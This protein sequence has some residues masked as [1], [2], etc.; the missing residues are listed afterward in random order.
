LLPEFFVRL[1]KATG[2]IGIGLPDITALSQDPLDVPTAG[3]MDQDPPTLET[4]IDQTE[5][6]GI[7]TAPTLSDESGDD[8]GWTEF[9]CLIRPTDDATDNLIYRTI[10][11]GT[12]EITQDTTRYVGVEYNSGAPQVVARTS[13]TFNAGTDEFLMAIVYNDG[14][15]LHIRSLLPRSGNFQYWANRRLYE[16]ERLQHQ[17]GLALGESAGANRYVTMSAGA[18]YSSLEK[19]SIS[20]FDTSGADRFDLYYRDA[21]SGFTKVAS[22]QSWPN[23]QYDDDSGTL[24][25]LTAAYYG[26]LWFYIETDGHVVCLY[27]RGN[28]QTIA[29]A[30]AEN[31]PSTLPSRLD[32]TGMLMGRYIFVKSATDPTQIDTAFPPPIGGGTA[33]DHGALTGLGDD[34]HGQYA[35]LDGRTGGQWLR[36]GPVGQAGGLTLSVASGQALNIQAD[37]TVIAQF[38]TSDIQLWK[39]INM[40]T[41]YD[42]V[43]VNDITGNGGSIFSG[44]TGSGDDL[45]LQ[46]TTHATHGNIYLGANDYYDEVNEEL[47]INTT[48][49]TGKG[50]NIGSAFIGNWNYSTAYAA[51]CHSGF[52]AVTA[53]YALLQHS[54][55]T[56]YLNAKSG[57]RIYFRIGNSTAME[58][59]HSPSE[60][61]MQTVNLQMNNT[62]ILGVDDITGNGGS[63]FSGGSGASENIYIQSTTHATKG[64]VYLDGEM[65]LVGRDDRCY[66]TKSGTQSI[67]NTT[68]TAVTFDG[69]RFDPNGL[70]SVASNTSRIT[71]ADAGTY[72]IGGLLSYAAAASDTTR[73]FAALSVNGVPGVGTELIRHEHHQSDPGGA[74][75]SQNMSCCILYN[76]SASDYVE[77]CAWQS[78][79]GALNV[80]TTCHFW[81]MRISE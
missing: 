55:G 39:N 42:I 41:V 49:A 74:G 56:T 33:D 47:H 51:F 9:T 26:N 59:G 11:T 76:L 50:A 7:I 70:H 2:E 27:G 14:G 58:L 61:K 4:K 72:L 29:E 54:A 13:D 48:P 16:V 32:T 31:P 10:A 40:M 18:L 63:I 66:L 21:G 36:G 20:A 65:P 69:E 8:L 75:F 24:A 30:V 38:G 71:V 34:D 64:S 80:A 43:G 73:R 6:A 28:H 25:D 52:K 45:Y 12:V 67:A 37:S 3:S 5:S 60:L 46:S 53:D 81:I 77:L 44:G 68:W 1:Q 17:S 78:S 79:G 62:D 57:T 23:A 22:Q 35:Y 19:Y 15:T